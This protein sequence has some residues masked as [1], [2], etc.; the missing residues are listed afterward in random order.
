MEASGLGIQGLRADLLGFHIAELEGGEIKEIACRE[1]YRPEG[2]L[3][4]VATLPD[5]RGQ[6][7]GRALVGAVETT[8]AAE[9]L[10]RLFLLTMDA[11]EYFGGLGYHPVPRDT[12]GV[13][14]QAS[15]Q[16]AQMCPSSVITMMRVLVRDG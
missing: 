4:S 13:H 14:M 1:S 16:F 12:A 2:L 9:G 3:R 7:I 11:A 8:A 5:A 6:G 10:Q 15:V